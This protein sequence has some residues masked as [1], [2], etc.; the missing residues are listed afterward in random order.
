MTRVYTSQ[1][2]PMDIVK[3][4]AKRIQKDQNIKLSAA[5]EAYAVENGYESWSDLTSKAIEVGENFMNDLMVSRKRGKDYI[6]FSFKDA[7]QALLDDPNPRLYIQR[8]LL[9]SEEDSVIILVDLIHDMFDGDN[10]LDPF[11]MRVSFDEYEWFDAVCDLDNGMNGYIIELLNRI[12]FFD[13]DVDRPA[14]FFE[15]EA[16][17]T[18]EMRK[19]GLTVGDRVLFNTDD[20]KPSGD[21]DYDRRCFGNRL[22]DGGVV[23]CNGA[24]EPADFIFSVLSA[25]EYE[26]LREEMEAELGEEAYTTYKGEVW[27]FNRVLEPVRVAAQAVPEPC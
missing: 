4:E 2:T 25:S 3:R 23:L 16:A 12:G 5:Q 9:H 11:E 13:V 7:L 21:P 22:S 26:D 19:I 20:L 14:H 8:Q 18:L 15:H 17:L 24:D 6:E 27:M 10:G 1:G